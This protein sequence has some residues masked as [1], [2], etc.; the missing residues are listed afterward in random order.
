MPRRTRDQ[1]GRCLAVNRT[2]GGRT[3]IPQ[4]QWDNYEN[5]VLE[6]RGDHSIEVGWVSY[7]FITKSPCHFDQGIEVEST[8][9][10]FYDMVEDPLVDFFNF[11]IQENYEENK[12]KHINLVSLPHFFAIATKYHDTLLF[13]FKVLCRTYGYAH[14]P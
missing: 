3:S 7:N 11:P 2:T 8:S 5:H 6:K 12:M 14:D 1:F 4:W 10:H 9:C 13:E